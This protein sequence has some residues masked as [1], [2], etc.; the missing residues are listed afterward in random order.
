MLQCCPLDKAG[1]F[2]I[3]LI[4]INGQTPELDYSLQLPGTLKKLFKLHFSTVIC[5][6]TQHPTE[7]NLCRFYTLI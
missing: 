2:S 6:L 4:T 5:R 1:F 3:P 7:L